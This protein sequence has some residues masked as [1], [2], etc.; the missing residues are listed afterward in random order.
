MAQVTFINV[1]KVFDDNVVAVRDV[2][3]TV[4]DKELLV[5]VGPSGCGKSTVLRM[6]AGLEEVSEGK[7]LFDGKNVTNLPPKDRDVAMVFQN[8]ALYPHMSVFDNLAFGLKLRKFSHEEIGKRVQDA[9]E[10]LGIDPYLKR[11]P[12]ALSG[13]QRQRVAL[14]RAIVR[15]PSVFLFDEPLSNLDAKMRVQMRTEIRKLNLR[16]QTTMIY[17]THD[18]VEA[19]TLGDRLAVMNEGRILQV[20]SPLELYDHPVDT[21]VAAF[22]GS[23]AMN[24]VDGETTANG[25]VKTSFTEFPVPT[26]FK[27]ALAA[28]G[29]KTVK[30]GIRPEDIHIGA[31]PGEASRFHKV[32]AAVEVVEP[33]GNEIIFHLRCGEVELVARQAAEKTFSPGSTIEA[34]IDLAKIHFFESASGRTLTA[35]AQSARA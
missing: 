3:L 5:L 11:R 8:Y 30:I 13:G 25:V 4:A 31:A 6:V 22:I 2:N 34:L 17:V 20:G 23:P 12:K 14:G 33:L 18:Q 10:L 29:G 21:F 15:H 1:K 35:D 27:S 26:R 16:I 28:V 32:S 24:F 9:A 7:I 19:M